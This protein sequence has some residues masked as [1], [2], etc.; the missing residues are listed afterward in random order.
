MHKDVER[1]I[2]LAKERG[3]LTLSQRELILNK[4]QEL[5][6]DIIEVEFEE[7]GRKKILANHP[8]VRKG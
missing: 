5:G 2:A 1:L 7:Q 6:D 4:A 3:F 8:A